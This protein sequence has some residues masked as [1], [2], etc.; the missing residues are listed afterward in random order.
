MP[1]R[2]YTGICRGIKGL[3]FIAF[4]QRSAIADV[5]LI[6][7]NILNA[8]GVAGTYGALKEISA[9]RVDLLTSTY[10]GA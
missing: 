6:G 3:C 10:A 9:K 5:V 1:A 8:S 2:R 4:N 7:R